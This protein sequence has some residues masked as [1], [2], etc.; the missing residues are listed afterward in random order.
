M[1][2][3]HNVLVDDDGTARISEYGLEVVLRDEASSESTPTNTWW[4]APEIRSASDRRVLSGGGG[5]AADI[6][7][8]AMVMFEVR[9]PR[10]LLN[11]YLDISPLTQV[12]TGTTPF[13]DESDEGVVDMV[14][15]ELRPKRPSGDPSQELADEL[16]E[17]IVACWN[18]KPDERPSAF[19]VLRALGEAKSREDAHDSDEETLVRDCDSVMDDPGAP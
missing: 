14:N 9:P 17:Q 8:F 11:V 10:V 2:L 13:P 19:E 15:A 16:W 12:L 4:M 18:N 7:S 3:Q 6:Y 1:S 5:G